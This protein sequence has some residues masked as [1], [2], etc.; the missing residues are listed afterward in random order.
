MGS[1]YFTNPLVFLVQVLF[2]A[3]ILVVMLRFLLQL[4]RADFYNPLSQFIV[5]VTSPVL[6]PIRRIIPGVGGIDFASVLLMW[7]LQAIELALVVTILGISKNPLLALAWAIPELLNL[8]INVFLVAIFI[9][10]IL[11][12]INP[13][14]YNPASALLYTLTEPV[15]RPARRIIPPLSG[16]DLS[17][18]A[19]IIMLILLKMLLIPPLQM[20]TGSPFAPIPGQAAFL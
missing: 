6:H 5:R 10:V 8:L 13:G 3:Y 11:S 20:V 4:L 16:L 12:W 19:V 7:I 14:A 9:Q 18:W 15:L 2:S 1:A 17:P